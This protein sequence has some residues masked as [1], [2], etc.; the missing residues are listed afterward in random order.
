MSPRSN[1]ARRIRRFSQVPPFWRSDGMSSELRK[2]MSLG[3]PWTGA[4]RTPEEFLGRMCEQEWWTAYEEAIAKQLSKAEWTRVII[5][6]MLGAS[7]EDAQQGTSLFP[8]QDAE[9]GTLHLGYF[10]LHAQPNETEDLRLQNERLKSLVAQ[11][12]RAAAREAQKSDQLLA[13][14]QRLRGS[15]DSLLNALTERM[16]ANDALQEALIADKEG[17]LRMFETH[18]GVV[19]DVAS[20]GVV[21]TYCVQGEYLDQAYQ[22]DQ[23]IDGRLPRKGDRLGAYVLI[24]ELPKAQEQTPP[25]STNEQHRHRDNAI[26]PP[27]EF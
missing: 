27:R 25:P 2:L 16:R 6:P 13:E 3:S 17:R 12:R 26:R 24:A 8:Y 23:F 9:E 14:L 20:E 7:I 10:P 1:I 21:V 4:E 11:E 22:K 5:V 15:F 18:E 19:V